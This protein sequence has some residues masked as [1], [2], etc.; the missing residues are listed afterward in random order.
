MSPYAAGDIVK[1]YL[2]FDHKAHIESV[3]ASYEPE[4]GGGLGA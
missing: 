4:S 2:E 1:L 3:W